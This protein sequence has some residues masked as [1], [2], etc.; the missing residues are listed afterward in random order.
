MIIGGLFQQLYNVADMLILGKFVG[1]RAL[2]SV[3]VTGSTFFF[4]ISLTIGLTNAFSIVMSQYFG[5]KKYENGKE[6]IS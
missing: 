2:A 6:D 4:L 1:S 3:G 5:A